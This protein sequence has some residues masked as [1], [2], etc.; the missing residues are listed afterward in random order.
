[1]TIQVRTGVRRL[2]LAAALLGLAAGGALAQ[3]KPTTS[4][5]FISILKPVAPPAGV[6]GP[7]IRTRGLTPS[8]GAASGAARPTTGTAATS[9][10]VAAPAGT[11]GSGKVPDLQILFEFN[12]AELTQQA[13]DRLDVLGAAL[14]SDQLR[15]YAFQIAGHTDAVGGQAYNQ[16]LSRRRAEAVVGYLSSRWSIERS[17]LQARGYGMSQLLEPSDGA[18]AKNRRVEVETLAR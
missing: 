2:A 8:T 4:Q 17:R 11:A 1:M 5:D 6:A 9:T 16:D 15:P 10:A 7:Q 13:R 3:G 12:S 18:S 14:A